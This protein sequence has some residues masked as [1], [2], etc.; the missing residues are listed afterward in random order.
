MS[1]K[2]KTIFVTGGSRGI[3]L[4]IALRAAGG[5]QKHFLDLADDVL[6]VH[7]GD[8]LAGL[9]PHVQQLRWIR[10]DLQCLVHEIPLGFARDEPTIA[11]GLDQFGSRCTVKS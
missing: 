6:P 1:L 11:P 3:G 5:F 4:A 2:G 10:G 9:L 8:A 7:A